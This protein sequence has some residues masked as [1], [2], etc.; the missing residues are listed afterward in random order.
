MSDSKKINIEQIRAD[1]PILQQQVNGKPLVYL[2]N[3]ATTQKPQVVIDA[4]ANYYRTTNSNVHR[5]AHTLSDQA[6]QMFENARITVQKFL[7]A[8]KSEEIIW[9]R[10]TTDAINLVAQTWVRSNVKAGDEIIISG[11][12]H[13][14]NIVPWQMVCEQTGAVLKIIPVLEDGSL[15]YDGYLKLL[16]DKTKFVAVV[17]V[18]NSLGTVNPVEDI[19]REAHNVGAKTL[20]DGAQAIA[21]WDIDVQAL[22]CDFY[23]FSGH[24]LF[25]PT[26]LGVL[27]G[28]E[29]LLNAMPPYQGGGEMILHVSFEKTTYNVLP[30]KFEAGTPNIAGAIGMAAAIDYVHGLDRIAL[31]QHEDAL[32]ARANELIAQT[33]GIRVIGTSKNKVSVLSFLIEGTHPH[34]VGTL[35]D[36]Q[37]I[38]VRTGHHCTMP[39]MDQF[40]IP[41]T[42]RASFTFYNTLEEVDALFKAIEKVK[43]FL[44]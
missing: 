30:Y 40:E 9:T 27:Y 35:L 42:V 7:N 4:I 25:G 16:S 11:M 32:L 19:I 37:G 44:L 5:G 15:D 28:K 10:G 13:H 12:E 24:K 22:D 14:S 18:S 36:Q 31:A 43:M 38:A 21:H 33:E 41:G 29:A 2:D 6:T 26:G 8:E 20:I 3:G 1:F 34:D 17:H 23:A 39:L